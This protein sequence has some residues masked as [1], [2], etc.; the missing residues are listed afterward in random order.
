MLIRR[1]RKV[2]LIVA[3]AAVIVAGG[4]VKRQMAAHADTASCTVSYGVT[5]QTTTGF[6]A[7]ITVTNLGQAISPWALTWSF[8]S[9]QTITSGWNGVF[10]QSDRDV[11]VT[12]A[13]R[14]TSLRAHRGITIGFEATWKGSNPSPTDFF[15]NGAQCTNSAASASPS[16]SA[17]SS[18]SSDVSSE[19]APPTALVTPLAEVWSHQE[20]TYS[21]LY[22]F[23]NYGW[24]QLIANNGT[25]NYCVRWDSTATVTSTLRDQIHEAIQRQISHWMDQMVDNGTGWN[26]FPYTDVDVN[27]VGWAVRD[28]SVLQWTDDSVDIYVNDI[29]EDAPQCSE[30]CGRFF[31]QDGNYPNCPGGADHHYDMSLWLTSGFS[32]GAGGDWGQ[33]VS[34]EYFVGAVNDDNI[35]IVEHEIGH[36][37]G[38]DDFY[39]WTPTGVSNF[40]MLA[41][42]AT[43]VTEFDSWMLR[44]WW[45]HLK[46]RYGY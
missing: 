38:L 15:L 9:G 3:L 4:I 42:S 34:S 37:F 29:N 7:E 17:S 40:I 36:S 2:T 43:E 1:S 26:S 33:R 35:H 6:A 30:P 28:A 16:A 23:M 11:T 10:S 27:V 46:S 44:D 41:G 20:S 32:G 5:S 39:D 25:L 18:S 14:T 8:D 21:N 19:W 22:S 13:R 24:D 45:R 31:H 12:N